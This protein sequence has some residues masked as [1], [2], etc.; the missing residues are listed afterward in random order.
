[1]INFLKYFYN[2]D[3]QEIKNHGKY[4]EFIYQD[5]LYKLYPVTDN[6]DINFMVNINKRLQG[7]TLIS[8]IIINKDKQAVSMYNGIAY[9]LIKIYAS[10]DKRITLQDIDYLS[11]VLVTD[12]IK[13][14]YGLLWS[15]KIDY[16]EDLINEN[17]K[18]YPIIVDSFNYFVG[19]A[20][21]AISYYNAIPI[22]L[23]YNYFISHKEI[24][25]DDTV[26]VLYNP[27]NIIFDYKVRDI[28][29]YIK[30]AFWNNYHEIDKEINMYMMN[31]NLSIIDIKI[32]V[33]RLMYPSFYFK[34]YEDILIDG[35]SEIMITKITSRL[36]EYERYLSRVINYFKERYEIDDI[37]WLKNSLK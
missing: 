33:A 19:M 28:A 34:L 9:M 31:N 29:E 14:N 24:S 1:M 10:N 25:P 4:Y 11:K 16:L 17:G 15:R 27:F 35:K 13:V 36:P 37:P 26:Q 22:P 30:N 20:E 12:R 18:K 5:Y 2:I 32:L 23:K 7:I 21:N 3:V 8:E 6:D